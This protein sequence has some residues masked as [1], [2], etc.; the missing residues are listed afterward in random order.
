MQRR[1]SG[2]VLLCGLLCPAWVAYGAEDPAAPPPM[3]AAQDG[4]VSATE[5]EPVIIEG[6]PLGPTREEMQRRMRDK[7][8]APPTFLESERRLDSG[9]VEVTTGLGRLCIPP[10]PNRVQSNLGGSVTLA[11]PCGSF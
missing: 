8:A 2:C 11:A 3:N 5:I 6:E 10:P 1:M 7:L 4:D 9:G